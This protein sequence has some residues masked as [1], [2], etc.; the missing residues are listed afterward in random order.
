MLSIKTRITMLVLK[1]THG[2]VFYCN[3]YDTPRFE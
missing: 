3:N 2:F 1:I